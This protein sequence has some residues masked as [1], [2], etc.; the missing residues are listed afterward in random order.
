VYDMKLTQPVFYV[1]DSRVTYWNVIMP[2]GGETLQEAD[3][4]DI[5]N[6]RCFFCFFTIAEFE[7]F[8]CTEI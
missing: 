1:E 2:P 6:E 4:M 5:S 7:W 3:T 8:A